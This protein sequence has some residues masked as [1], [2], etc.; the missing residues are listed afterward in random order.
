L[1][2]ADTENSRIQIFD[3]NGGLLREI[4]PAAGRESFRFPRSVAISSQ[5]G[6]IY[7]VDELDFRIYVFDADGKQVQV[8]DRRRS[9]TEPAAIPGRLAISPNGTIYVSEPNGH[10]VMSYNASHGFQSAYGAGGELQSPSGLVIGPKSTLYVLDYGQCRVHTFDSK[11]KPGPSFGRRGSGQG[12]FSVPRDLTVDR[13][14][15]A[16]VADT[17]NHRVQIFDPNGEPI[18]VLGQKGK[19]DG[20]FAG[21]E[22][23]ALSPDD[24]LYV[25]DRGNGRI[26]VFQVER[27]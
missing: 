24:L 1:Y 13:S 11:G 7:V 14:G 25:S 12:E 23:I 21:P 20:M 18:M 19:A 6:K 10:R 2:V 27:G 5:N 22:G 3:P 17:L 16:F 8:W 4:R 9:Q 15:Y 26:Q